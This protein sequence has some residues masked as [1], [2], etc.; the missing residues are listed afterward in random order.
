MRFYDLV[1]IG[2][3]MAAN[4]LLQRLAE[5]SNRPER[6]LILGEE[7]RPAY[8][9]VLLSPLLAGEISNEAL[10][11]NPQAWYD[12]QGFEY[13]TDTRVMAID[14]ASKRLIMQSGQQLNYGK[15]VLATGSVPTVP[16]VKGCSL[17][18]VMGFRNWQDVDRLSRFARQRERIRAPR[19]VVIGGGLLGLEAAE[20]LRKQGVETTLLHRAE[21]LLNRQLDQQAGTMLQAALS[22]RGLGI[23]TRARLA[24]IETDHTE[25]FA[26]I[27][28][29]EDG[30]HI[31]TDLV[32]MAIGITPRTE[33]A[34]E[35]GLSCD[36]AIR[37][38]A[39]LRTSDPDVYALGECCE[40][41]GTTY[42]LVAPI[43]RQAETLAGVLCGRES[44]PYKEEAIATQLKVSGIELFS[45]GEINSEDAEVMTFMDPQ[46]REYRRLWLRDN[47]LVG[48]ILYGDVRFGQQYHQWIVSG[49][50]CEQQRQQLLFPQ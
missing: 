1:I 23:I 18:F 29:L 48:A 17:P 33:L 26:G 11:L 3:G 8:N 19:A 45:S 41:D 42:G 9:R 16:K 2:H 15:L 24:S 28:T 10:N 7:I 30:K 25:Q 12:E 34:R 36:R 4:R 50:S 37:V 22:E 35:A 20:G 38:N 44:L 47:Q 46:T 21:T 14:P 43:W 6:V 32:V 27:V 13:R 5:E 39:F 49:D 40:F 31:M